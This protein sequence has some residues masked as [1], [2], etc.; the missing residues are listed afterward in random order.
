MNSDNQGG[1]GAGLLFV[2]KITTD[3]T[4]PLLYITPISM[5]TSGR[6]GGGWVGI[7]T[8]R[9]S[10]GNKDAANREMK[11][12]L[13]DKTYP[14]IPITVMKMELTPGKCE[15]ERRNIETVM[16]LCTRVCA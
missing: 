7:A 12:S 3:C 5:E 15:G 8:G 10:A 1:V 4:E 16:K 9:P 14:C 2:P 11:Q 6:K 13:E